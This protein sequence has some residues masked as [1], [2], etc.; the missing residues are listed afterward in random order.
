M[1]DELRDKL[2]A[3]ARAAGYEVEVCGD[4]VIRYTPKWRNIQPWKPHCKF[5]H[6]TRLAFDCG[7]EVNYAVGEVIVLEGIY[8]GGLTF[9]FTPGDN[10]SFCTAVVDAAAEMGRNKCSPTGQ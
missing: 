6:A 9:N 1:K 2:L 7:M 4:N 10:Q 5:D 8:E 3:A